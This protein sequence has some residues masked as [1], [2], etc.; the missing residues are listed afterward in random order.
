MDTVDKAPPAQALDLMDTEAAFFVMRDEPMPATVA[1]PGSSNLA[2]TLFDVTATG[3]VKPAS[4]GML[5]LTLYGIAKADVSAASVS[6]SDWLPLSSSVAEPIGGPNELTE[7]M[8]M[9][10]GKDLMIFP[11]SGKLQGTFQSNVASNPQAPIDIQQHPG[12]IEDTDPLYIFAVGASFEPSG[13]ASR[14][15]KAT[16]SM[17]SLTLASFTIS[18]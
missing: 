2:L 13:G 16:E 15:A 7:T 17:C 10:Q 5:T 1:L 18:A 12:D 9:I 14:T 6:P 11:G 3:S 8:W 4:P